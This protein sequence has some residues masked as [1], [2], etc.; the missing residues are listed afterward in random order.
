[1]NKKRFNLNSILKHKWFK[2]VSFIILSLGLIAG[3]L[4]V[5]KNQ[6]IREKAAPATTLSVSPSTQDKNANT[7]FSFYIFLDSGSNNIT[8]IDI[9]M[10]YDP[11]IIR[12]ND[13]APTPEL[14]VFDTILKNEIDN[15][16]GRFRYA[17]ATFD[18]SK[19]LTGSLNILSVSGSILA[20][21]P[22]GNY[23]ITFNSS[24]LI[25][26]INEK[27][28]VL[29]GTTPGTI[30]V[31]ETPEVTDAPTASPTPTD[32]PIGGP[33]GEPNSCG[34][35]CGSNNNCRTDLFCYLGFCRNPRC[36]KVVNCNCPTVTNPPATSQT[37]YLTATTKPN[38][39]TKPTA[40]TKP[41]SKSSPIA[42]SDFGMTRVLLGSPKPVEYQT[43][44]EEYEMPVENN[45]FA[46]YAMY[47]FIGFALIAVI[48]II[49][50]IKMYNDK[51]SS[52]VLPPT[53]L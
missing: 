37:T 13:L 11:S 17:H 53:N 25:V 15:S 36:E 30:K 1:M 24:S 29:S 19:A 7:D 21:A 33:V 6:D 42:D 4:L 18:K 8:G 10:D 3:L 2:F 20:N 38:T 9:V 16:T 35:T 27:Q 43:D 46:K 47:I 34:G 41:T 40:T 23:N 50:A 45:F 28:N 14:A 44:L 51:N 49:Y 32:P 5:Q 12:I 22:V 31:V 26:A 39:T 48:V 52:H